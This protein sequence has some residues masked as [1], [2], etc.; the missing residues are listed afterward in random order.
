MF[1]LHALALPLFLPSA[2]AL[3]SQLSAIASSRRISIALPSAIASLIASLS[4]DVKPT[5]HISVP[6]GFIPLVLNL[7]TQLACSAGVNAL[8]GSLTAPSVALVLATRK[9][10]SLVLSAAV[11]GASTVRRP[12]EM[13]AGAVLVFIGS[14]G[15]AWA[16]TQASEAV[17]KKEKDE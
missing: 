9:A 6:S 16:S 10:V 15:W 8:T 11:F 12:V 7:I 17:K 5:N 4:S 1:Y 2:S 13:G 14:V 3:R